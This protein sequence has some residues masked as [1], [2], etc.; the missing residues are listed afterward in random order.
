M[1][2]SRSAFHVVAGIFSG[3]AVPFCAV[4][5]EPSGTALR[6]PQS[7]DDI[8]QYMAPANARCLGC[9]VVTNIRQ[10]EAKQ[11]AGISMDAAAELRTGDIGPGEDIQTVTVAGTGSASREARQQA[12]RPPENPWR[13]TVRYDDGSYAS[14]DQDDRPNVSRGQRVQVVS[15]RVEPR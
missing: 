9:G 4:A 15:G 6:L 11:L 12:A 10:V 7:A 8:R 5:E 3:L 1:R 2:G 14:F 13:I